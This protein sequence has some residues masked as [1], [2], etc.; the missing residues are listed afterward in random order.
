MPQAG[1]VGGYRWVKC[2]GGHSETNSHQGRG[3]TSSDSEL[4]GGGPP[5]SENHP[6]GM[7]RLLDSA[8]M[9]AR[10][11]NMQNLLTNF[12]YLHRTKKGSYPRMWNILRDM[13]N[14]NILPNQ[15]KFASKVKGSE[16]A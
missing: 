7:D 12:P 11:V 3:D 14:A 9:V 15:E 8:G 10:E 16:R 4:E 2:R 13:V 5:G 6:N 1:L